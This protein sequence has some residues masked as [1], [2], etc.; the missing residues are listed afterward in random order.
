MA[1]VRHRLRYPRQYH[2]E[3]MEIRRLTETDA[4]SFRKLRLEALDRER[5]SFA[6]SVEE[7]R[8]TTVDVCAERLRSG[9]MDRFVFGAIET[10]ALLGMAGFY[11]ES[12]LKYRH[13]GRIWGV[14][15][16][17]EYRGRGAG[18]ALLTQLLERARSLPDLTCMLLS[19]AATQEAARNL[20]VSLGFRVFGREPRSLRVNGAYIDEEH[21]ILELPVHSPIPA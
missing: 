10:S 4:E 14:Y 21:M 12:H 2:R 5:T 6:E 20:Y 1:I 3:A 13:K 15:V 18:R 7:F 11:R 16:R 8:N 19:V 9:G 17:E